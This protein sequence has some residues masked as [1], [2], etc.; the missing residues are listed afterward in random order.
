MMQYGFQAS[1]CVVDEEALLA[2]V[3][4]ISSCLEQ[5]G[6]ILAEVQTIWTGEKHLKHWSDFD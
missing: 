5:I 2:G 1:G 3:S 4:G 6:Y